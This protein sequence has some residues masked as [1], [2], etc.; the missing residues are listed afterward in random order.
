M[1]QIFGKWLASF[2]E[3]Q[4]KAAAVPVRTDTSI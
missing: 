4:Q 3:A 2:E 1:D